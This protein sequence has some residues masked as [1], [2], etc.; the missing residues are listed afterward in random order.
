[1]SKAEGPV[2]HVEND[3]QSMTATEL[4]EKR[5]NRVNLA[6]TQL[7]SLNH[8]T[9]TNLQKDVVFALHVVEALKQF[10]PAKALDE[11][12]ERAE[13]E[14]LPIYKAARAEMERMS[15]PLPDAKPTRK[16][17]TPVGSLPVIAH[18]PLERR[19]IQEAADA[20]Q[21]ALGVF[22]D[23]VKQRLANQ[24]SPV[25][26]Q[27]RSVSAQKTSEETAAVPGNEEYIGHFIG[28]GSVFAKYFS[29]EVY[30][31]GRGFVKPGY[32]GFGEYEDDAMRTAPAALREHDW[33][34]G[35]YIDTITKLTQFFMGNAK[36]QVLVTN[37]P[38][39]NVDIT[40]SFAPFNE[41]VNVRNLN[42]QSLQLVYG[43]INAIFNAAEKFQAGAA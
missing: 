29:P 33:P 17:P 18:P 37:L 16:G 43:T 7:Q 23:Q 12:V 40:V 26:R 2:L 9:F 34:S 13:E 38:N 10:V 31:F 3:E 39:E 25:T 30:A 24:P 22:G 27:P 14:V 41:R 21:A 8:N 15:E 32:G 42:V 28:S 5:L 4:L 11:A 35:F 36:M 1:M 6:L 19:D 20:A